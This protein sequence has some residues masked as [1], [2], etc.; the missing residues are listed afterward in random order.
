MLPKIG[1]ISNR[2]N[3]RSVLQVVA[4]FFKQQ[5]A[6]ISGNTLNPLVLGMARLFAE[7][8]RYSG[9]P[10]IAQLKRELLDLSDFLLSCFAAVIEKILVTGVSSRRPVLSVE[11]L[12]KVEPKIELEGNEVSVLSAGFAL[13]SWLTLQRMNEEKEAV[14]GACFEL[15]KPRYPCEVRMVCLWSVS[16]WREECKVRVESVM[17]NNGGYHSRLNKSLECTLLCNWVMLNELGTSNPHIRDLLK[18]NERENERLKNLE[19]FC[20]SSGDSFTE[21]V[22]RLRLSCSLLILQLL[23]DL[24]Q[25][26]PTRSEDPL[27]TTFTTEASPAIPNPLLRL[28]STS[29]TRRCWQELSQS[30]RAKQPSLPLLSLLLAL[31]RHTFVPSGNLTGV[32]GVCVGV[33]LEKRDMDLLGEILRVMAEIEPNCVA[34]YR[35]LWGR[36]GR[37]MVSV[38]WLDGEK[39]LNNISLLQCLLKHYPLFFP[40][41]ENRVMPL[42]L[43]QVV[44]VAGDR[45]ALFEC[46]VACFERAKFDGEEAVDKL[47][48][49]IVGLWGASVFVPVLPLRTVE[50]LIDEAT[51]DVDVFQLVSAVKHKWSCLDDVL[52]MASLLLKKKASERVWREFAFVVELNRE[53]EKSELFRIVEQCIALLLEKPDENTLHYVISLLGGLTGNATCVKQYLSEDSPNDVLEWV[54]VWSIS[55]LDESIQL[56]SLYETVNKRALELRKK[57]SDAKLERLFVKCLICMVRKSHYALDTYDNV[58][59]LYDQRA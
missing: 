28:P 42:L 15:C 1:V 14:V 29:L 36:L 6:S 7:I 30:V 49:E 5:I 17:V 27:P 13:V 44:T 54:L 57:R 11:C 59:S 47:V 37:I 31:L 33:S 56:G 55:S 16:E 38:L 46:T 35:N 23:H 48:K 21:W 58:F 4:A 45:G 2:S 25:L 41:I 19:E 12:K 32:I 51:N 50:Y 40:S 24:K 39:K 8:M 9:N 43:Q 10:I 22:K 3:D 53:C 18:E 26:P 20:Q 52:R 34:V